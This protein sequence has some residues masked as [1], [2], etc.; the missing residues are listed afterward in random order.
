MENISATG[1]DE[2]IGV[3]TSLASSALAGPELALLTDAAVLE[4]ITATDRV[5]SLAEAARA[6]AIRE[7]ERREAA[8]EEAHC[9]TAEWIRRGRGHSTQRCR[10]LVR[11]AVRQG[12]FLALIGAV[13]TGEVRSGQASAIA[14]VLDELPDDFSAEQ[15]AKA[16]ETMIELAKEFG[17]ED[18]LRCG[19]HL[20]EVVAPERVDELMAE[21]L[22]R[23]EREALKKRGLSLSDD[24]HGVMHIKGRLPS[25]DGEAL[26]AVLNAHA[27]SAWKRH[28]DEVA[29]AGGDPGP[30]D[31]K[32]LLADALMALVRAHQVH[33]DAPTHGGDRPRV[34][35]FLKFEDLVGGL[36]EMAMSSGRGITA[37]EARRLAC[38]CD[39]IPMVLDSLGIPLDV[40]RTE[41]LVNPHLRAALV[42]RDGGCVF[43]GCDRGPSECEAH[44]IQPWWAGGITC[45]DN[46]VLLCPSHHRRCEPGRNNTWD[47]DDPD[48]WHVRLGPDR[49]PEVTPPRGYDPDRKKMRHARF[50]LLRR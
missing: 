17:P 29:E 2:A 15:L 35:V 25:A 16:E 5:V 22:E 31:K 18:L 39:L 14:R 19:W 3:I 26:A 50:G 46:L 27:E 4:L 43:P 38:D 45:L 6:E 23:E 7:A 40:G 37:Y 24:G 12:R 11:D 42:A 28:A 33:R 47:D 10:S 1:L 48:R 49:L 30:K 20:L 44:H 13:A 32:V 34:N 9:A 36:G 8:Q 41:R 21:K